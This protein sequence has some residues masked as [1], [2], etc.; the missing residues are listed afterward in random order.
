MDEPDEIINSN[1]KGS[2]SV[3]K[4]RVSSELLV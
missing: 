4:T 3:S 1:K 2:V